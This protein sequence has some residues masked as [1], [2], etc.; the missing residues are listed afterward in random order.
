[1]RLRK[2]NIEN[3]KG[4]KTKKTIEFDAFSVIVGQNDVGK[5]TILKA[6]DCFL[7][8]TALTKDDLNNN[9]ESEIITVSLEFDPLGQSIIIDENI[10]TTF[11]DEEL[12][13]SDSLLVIKKK[14][15][16]SKSKITPD[17][18]ILRKVY[19]EHDFL[20]L[21]E[22]Q[23]ISK[24]GDLGIETQKANG[25]EFNNKEK[26]LKIRQ[27][28][29]DNNIDFTFEFEKLPT[30]GSNRFKIIHDR[31]K[32]IL[33][34][35]EYFKADTSLS[36][37]D[38]AIQKFFKSIAIKTLE[39]EID[40]SGIEGSIKEKLNEV[41]DNITAKIND[42]VGAEEEVKPTVDFDWTK[43][44]STKFQSTKDGADVPLSSRGDGFRRITMMA[45]F[46]YLAEQEASEYQKIIFG[47]EEPET[48]L[49]PS[50]QENLFHKLLDLCEN[51]YQV[52]I[53]THS[54]II[55]SNTQKSNLIHIHKNGGSYNVVQQINDVS[56]IAED[57]GIKVD[58]Q[59]IS[60]FD[61]AKVLFLVEGIDDVIAF[62]HVSSIY[63]NNGLTDHTI[64]EK[65]IAIIPIGGCDSMKHWVSL[66]LLSTL[67]KPYFI[68]QDSDKTTEDEDSPTRK[69]L[70]DMGFTE[71]TDFLISKK[72]NI[73][74][75]IHS[76]S[77]NRIVPEAGLEYG[78]FDN[79]KQICGRH[80]LAG[81][82]GGKGVTS[83]HFPNLTYEDIRST[84]YDGTE[85]EFI[86]VYN[87]LIEKLN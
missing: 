48:F 86:T 23:L 5:S 43:L 40:T 79:V 55:V 31:L 14:W 28:N 11:E 33:P 64:E 8:N 51:N 61:R 76:D 19:N 30:N 39:E 17:T 62:N 47:F 21:T 66:N 84:F 85:D 78:D 3:F 46:E 71:E 81:R 27:Y 60:M 42:V 59:F 75:Y 74:N 9:A 26:R 38:N 34:R 82:L 1:M 67:A 29:I 7:N 4:I 69:K 83:K 73:E 45:Y 44:V 52:I 72:R 56:S 49:H 25:D 24:C 6:V 22:R 70:E 68:F 18:F 20:S 65:E 15:D 87:K 36:E 80:A 16:T 58:N 10:P 35:F 37:S 63:K 32:K 53:S 77:L 57:L 54:P 12:L 2:I 41:L 13:S 50:G